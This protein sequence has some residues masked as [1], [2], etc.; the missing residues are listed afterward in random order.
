MCP[1]QRLDRECSF[2]VSGYIFGISRSTSYISRSSGK[3][4]GHRSK[5][6]RLCINLFMGGHWVVMGG[7]C[8]P[9][10][11]RESCCKVRSVDALMLQLP[12]TL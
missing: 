5:K 11:E 1:V 3:G 7:H 9:S 4:Q 2:L 6:A 12:S 10:V 8:L